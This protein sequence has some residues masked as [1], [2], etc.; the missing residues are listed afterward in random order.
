VH[1]HILSSDCVSASQQHFSTGKMKVHLLFTSWLVHASLLFLPTTSSFELQNLSGSLAGSTLEYLVNPNDQDANGQ[2]TVTIKITV[3]NTA[4]VSVGTS[5]TG[6]MPGAEAVIGKPQDGTVRKYSISAR[7]A[8]AID[9]M[10]E[11]QQT[12]INTD[13]VQSGGS[14]VMTYTK[15]LEEDG[16]IIINGNGDNTFVSAFGFGNSFS[17]HQGYGSYSVSLS[18]V[19]IE[20]P[21]TASPVLSPTD[22]PDGVEEDPTAAP[23]TA[24]PVLSPTDPPDGMEVVQLKRQLE[25]STFSY[26]VNLDDPATGG[27]NS[28]TVTLTVPSSGWLA[29]GTSENGVMVGSE[30]VIGY[31]DTGEVKK[32]SLNSQNENLSGIVEMP[33]EK[34]TLVNTEVT[35]SDGATTM[36]YTKIMVEDDEIPIN[37]FGDT[38]F[39]VSYAFSSSSTFHIA[40]GSFTLSGTV[41]ERD[42]SLWVIHGW[43]AAIAWGALCPL[44]IMAGVFRKFIPGESLWFQIHQTLNG[45]VVLLTVAAF[46]VAAIALNDETPEDLSANHFDAD[47]SDGHRLIGLVILVLALIQ[48]INGALRPHLP[49]KDTADENADEVGP[50]PLPA[51]EK[52]FMRRVWEVGHRLFGVALLFLCLYQVQLGIKWYH[53]IFNQGDYDSTIAIF[54]GVA[55]SLGGILVVGIAMRLITG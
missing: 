33:A 25:T 51:G 21:T 49:S 36:T 15:I 38:I 11:A 23:T 19:A 37:A 17:F 55:G 34:Q 1:F 31:P 4:W 2:D 9:E 14:T 40:K 45:L 28:I 41:I 13:L 24:S 43:L 47:F 6:L 26:K 29:V 30:A 10:P 18:T 16:E 46:A 3:P 35:Q 7:S 54:W 50:P 39:L 22:P 48:A 5:T 27:Q 53:N 44:A 32:Y 20:G 12:L 52:S 8:S 42:N